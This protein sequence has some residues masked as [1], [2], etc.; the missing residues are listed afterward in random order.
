MSLLR[1]ALLVTILSLAGIGSAACSGGGGGDPRRTPAG[2]ATAGGGGP[3]GGDGALIIARPEGLVEYI[4]KSGEQRGI[5]PAEPDAFL[6]DPAVSPDGRRLA[7][8]LQP[9]SKVIDNRY[10]AG[11]D[12]W[13]AGRD[14]SG[15]QPAFVH[16][17][18]SQLVR[19]PQ[20]LDDQH[21]V[22]IVQ[23]TELQADLAT[24][25]YTLQRINVETGERETLLKDVLGFSLSPDREHVVYAKLAI[26]VLGETLHV[27]GIDGSDERTL[28]TAEQN[29]TPFN[30]PQYSPDGSRIA[31]ASANQTQPLGRLASAAP[32]VR[33][34]ATAD[35]LPQDIFVIEAGGGSPRLA[36]DL[37]E[38]LP[39]LAWSGD[40]SHIYVLGGAGLYDVDMK[41]GLVTRIGEGVFHGGITWVP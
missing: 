40:G 7:Y 37:K 10:D 28:I 4:L 31:F 32:L 3:V 39:A 36:A 22:A 20:W 14:G 38:D 29:L 16:A 41:T 35:G 8:I 17:E 26:G 18:P 13:I 5:V 15:A 11:S 30:Y 25:V 9:P 27:A 1:F 33:R 6:L 23:E 19:F 34:A 12:L 2:A 24:I 21:V